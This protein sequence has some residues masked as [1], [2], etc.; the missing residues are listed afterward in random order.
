[1]TARKLGEVKRGQREG[2]DVGEDTDDILRAH[3]GFRPA[4]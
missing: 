3:C 1:M 2:H 4:P